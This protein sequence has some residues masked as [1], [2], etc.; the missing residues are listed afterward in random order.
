[1]KNIIIITVITIITIIFPSAVFAQT[2]TLSLDPANGTF[3]KGCSFSVNV[4]LGTG[5]ASTGG[6]DTI[7]FY[8]SSRFVAN[9]ITK[10]TILPDFPINNIDSSAGK[11]DIAA[12]PAVGGSSFNGKGT[13]F[14]LNFTVPDTAPAGATQIKFDFDPNDK[15]KTTD[16]NVIAVLQESIVDILDSV[17][18]GNYTIGTGSCSVQPTPAPAGTT[19]TTII[20]TPPGT[21]G[22][23]VTGGST[24]SSQLKP[25]PPKGQTLDQLVDQ[26]G[27][28][29]GTP[30]LTFTLAI[31]GGI[32]T[33]LG[34]LGL[35]LL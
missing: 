18:N 35:A 11:I 5:G 20:Q 26:T 14:S 10:G 19:P 15:A 21:G 32:L 27:K 24:P 23:V 30:Q 28:G 16:S 12:M 33:A 29:P 31:F 3:N 6:V 34:I 2:A 22:T 1:M 13:L 8:D 25:L 17:V 9:P 7:I 4:I